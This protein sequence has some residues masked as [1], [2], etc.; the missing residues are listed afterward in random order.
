M[1]ISKVA[2]T[3]FF[4]SI[5]S[6]TE[7]NAFGPY[8]NAQQ[9]IALGQWDK[10]SAIIVEESKGIAYGCFGETEGPHDWE[11]KTFVTRQLENGNISLAVQRA[12]ETPWARLPATS[13]IAKYFGREGR[14]QDAWDLT[15]HIE[16]GWNKV[17]LLSR[18][19]DELIA[20]KDFEG[21]E[22]TASF[23]EELS[24]SDDIKTTR[25]EKT[26]VDAAARLRTHIS[27]AQSEQ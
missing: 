20:L 27:E 21:V 1:N 8:E 14:Y 9:A 12:T 5:L 22:K 15:N 26:Y 16:G 11:L 13:I 19:A 4:A 25:L 17:F 10:A 23:L 18:L 3:L 24:Q 6:S 2:I 7:A